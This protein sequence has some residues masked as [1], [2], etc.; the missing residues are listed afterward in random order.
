MKWCSEVKET[1]WSK[2]VTNGKTNENEM[3]QE[4]RRGN[5]MGEGNKGRMKRNKE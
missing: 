1:K 3:E 2:G 4:K 5:E